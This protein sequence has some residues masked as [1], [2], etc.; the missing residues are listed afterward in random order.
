MAA[1]PP[2]RALPTVTA[3]AAMAVA[4]CAGDPELGRLERGLEAYC[5]AEVDGSGALDVEGDYLPQVVACEN[6]AADF[7]ALKAQAVAA[8][9]FLYYKL[10]REGRIGDGQG[11]QV[12]T[13]G[14][15]A[16]DEHRRAVE[17]TSGLVLVYG[18][19]TVAAFYVAG[20]FQDPPSCA[21]G[22]DD[23][24]GTE[25]FV[26]YNEGLSGDEIEQT[27]LGLVDPANFANRG[28]QSQNGADCLSRAGWLDPD[29][30][31][32]YYGADIE[33]VR[34]EGACVVGGEPPDPPG[35]PPDPPGQPPADE[36]AVLGGGGGCGAG[37]RDGPAGAA[38][39]ALLGLLSLLARRRR[40]T[41]PGGPA[42]SP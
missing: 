27:S 22:T 5:E 33:I 10:E 28:C 24:T 38:A 2:R 31:R 36:G 6:G 1:R 40:A 18:G 23:P 35:E 11:D 7:E 17:E 32:F 21:G 34:A 8:R 26:T 19:V 4:G 3:V 25:P 30:L 20:A 29:I 42:G 9:S 39:A 14:N 37:G 15:P 41:G 12:Y 16:G 13:C